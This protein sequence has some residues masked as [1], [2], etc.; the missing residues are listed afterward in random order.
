[1]KKF[2]KITLILFYFYNL[3]GNNFEFRVYQTLFQTNYKQGQNKEKNIQNISLIGADYSYFVPYNEEKNATVQLNQVFLYNFEFNEDEEILLKH[4]KKINKLFL[5]NY[6]NSY[7]GA[8]Y[9]TFFLLLG[10]IHPYNLISS[11]NEKNN[12]IFNKIGIFPSLDFRVEFTNHILTIS[13]LFLYRRENKFTS[14]LEEKNFAILHFFKE[15]SLN[16]EIYHNH[17]SQKLHYAFIS[18]WFD[19]YFGYYYI[20]QENPYSNTKNDLDLSFYEYHFVFKIYNFILRLQI[21]QSKGNFNKGKYIYN[22]YGNR[23]KIF[24]NYFNE[25]FQIQLEAEK[26]DSS[27]WNN[28]TKKWERFGFTSIFND[29]I[30]TLQMSNTYKLASNYEI[31][32]NS[33]NFCEGIQMLYNDYHLILPSSNAFL[34]FKLFYKI[35]SFSFSLGYLIHTPI[36]QT[37]FLKQLENYRN[38]YFFEFKNKK[39]ERIE[40]LEP[41]FSITIDNKQVKINF[42]YSRIFKKEIKNYSFLSHSILFSFTYFF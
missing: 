6:Q 5:Y 19:F 24:I 7:L 31:C 40:F 21:D 3:F 13:P 20:N 17:F 14:S 12:L 23:Y 15:E 27:K 35:F 37:D 39:N 11:P 41:N 26:S 2:Y 9:K 38:N 1:M 29:Y 28:L 25:L 22:I 36:E 42:L 33:E 8:Y 32:Y 16:K 18:Q 10:Y 30:S 34:K 4:Q